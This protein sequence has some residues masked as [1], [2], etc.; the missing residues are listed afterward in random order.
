[1][2]AVCID[3]F[4]LKKREKYGTIMIDINTHAVI[5][6]LESR[7]QAE[8][9]EWLKSYPN[10]MIISRDGS[11]TYRNSITE[12]H[13]NAM[14]ISDRFHLLKN[15]TDYSIEY[16]KKH[17]KKNIGLIVNSTDIEVTKT[18]K[19]CRANKCFCQLKIRSTAH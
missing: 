16:L 12:A 15:L 6:M 5:D 2:T 9:A 14:Q 19:I 1:M 11:I 17:L 13:P 10:I 3:D 8:V 4:A 7:E 18:P